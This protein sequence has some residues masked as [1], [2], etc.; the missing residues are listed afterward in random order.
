MD[1]TNAA[2]TAHLRDRVVGELHLGRLH[3]GDRLPG[4][5][6]ISL[7]TG[8]GH[9]AVVRAYRALE[10]EGLVEVRGRSGVYVAPQ[11]RL[12]GEVLQETAS[13]LAD[14]LVEALKRRITIPRLPEFIQR[15]TATLRPRCA[16]LE[17]TEDHLVVL[18][19]EL[20]EEFGFDVHP[21]KLTEKASADGKLGASIRGAH[22]VVTTSFHGSF[23]RATAD[24]LQKPLVVLT[25]HPNIAATLERRLRSGRLTVVCADPAFA[26]RVRA[27]YGARDPDCVRTVLADDARAVRALDPE[28]PLLLTL[29]ARRRLGETPLQSLLPHSPTISPQSARELAELLVRLNVAKEHA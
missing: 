5:R 12:D 18:T 29:A 7:E 23:A 15:C 21:L 27:I 28:E 19:S 14:T 4:I 10:A 3:A 8:M 25:V 13:W 9:R 6:E 11:E 24:S 26:E 22:F 1:K 17:S 16:L 20:R 2:L